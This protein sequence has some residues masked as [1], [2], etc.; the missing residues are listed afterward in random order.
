MITKRDGKKQPL[1]RF[2]LH[3]RIA[4]L[5]DGLNADFVDID[6]IVDKVVAGTCQGIKSQE[7]DELAAETAAYLATDHPDY[8][9]LAARISVSA[10]HKVTQQTFSQKIKALYN[11]VHSKSGAK[12][13]KIASDVYEIVIENAETLDAAIDYSRDFTFDYFGYKTLER[14]YLLRIEGHVVERPQDMF[15]RVSVGIHKQD[16]DAAIQ[17]Y[18]LMSLKFFTHATP[19]LF[20]AGTPRNQLS[21]CFLLQLKDDS[22]EGIYETV[23]KCATISAQ[24][25]GIGISVHNVRAR[26]SYVE[27]S[28]G[29]ANGLIPML[30][31]FNS[32]ARLC[33]QGAGKRPGAFA[34]YLE[35]WHAEIFEFLELKKNFGSEDLRA[36]DLFYALW[37]PDLFMKRCEADGAWSLFCPVEAPGLCETYGEK[38]EELYERY[39]REGRARKTIKARELWFAILEAQVENGI[40]YLLYKDAANEKSNQKNLGIIK[41]SNLCTEIMEYTSKDE[42]AVCNL[43]SICLPRFVVEGQFDHKLLFEVTIVITR[44]LNKIIDIN[45]YP[46]KE[47]QTSNF[48]HRPIGIG[49]QGLADVFLLLRLPFESEEARQLN[50]DIFETI[51]FAAMT[52]SNQLAKDHGA[53][54]SFRGSPASMG[55]LQFDLWGAEPS[56]R[57]DWTSLKESIK[58]HGLRNSL[59]VAPMPTASTAQ[60]MGNNE[61]FEPYTSNIYNRR[62]MAGDFLVLNPHLLK[63]LI[64]LGLWSQKMKHRIMAYDGSIQDILEIPKDIR[65]LY[66]TAWEIKQRCLID[67]AADR[68][69]FIDQSQSLNLFLE[70]PDTAKLT[71]MHFYAWRK[72]LKT[73]VYYLRTRAAADAIKFTLD[74]STVVEARLSRSSLSPDSNSSEEVDESMPR[75][76]LDDPTDVGA[77]KAPRVDARDSASSIENFRRMKQ[78]ARAAA[79]EGDCLMCS[80]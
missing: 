26:G 67:M 24:A 25:G 37:M 28:S 58:E 56:P 74:H 44:N 39:E 43:A 75:Q 69:A 76:R 6:Q 60:I 72:G 73:G 61:C 13:P 15:M 10:L 50:R 9:Q 48:R 22:I 47:A 12:G 5:V 36:R 53:Y 57:W 33:S 55:L 63:D 42:V 34:V 79:G 14:S 3:A 17:T 59:T 80:S 8:S 77:A 4:R 68:G 2:K 30:K 11:H 16:I 46:V 71:S 62:V 66:K 7:I 52:A 18:N 21:S 23:G 51:Y 19:T 38:F 35:P 64:A 70:A 41:C 45:L 65:E 78:R 54:S 31:V 40:P 1:K 29:I 32:T 49:V 20:N 27:N